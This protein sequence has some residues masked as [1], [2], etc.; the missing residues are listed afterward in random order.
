MKLKLTESKLKQIIAES[1]NE[2]LNE[3]SSDYVYN[4]ARR[5]HNFD[6]D[7]SQ[8]F[9]DYATERLHSELG[10]KPKGIIEASNLF[11]QYRN[12]HGDTIMIKPDGTIYYKER[13]ITRNGD[14]TSWPRRGDSTLQVSDEQ[15]ANF[16]AKWCAKYIGNKFSN[17]SNPKFWSTTDPIWPDE[18]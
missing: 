7:R 1:I 13:Q 2:V 8:K 9:H 16:L 15:T 10:G 18:E 6:P 5:T 14:F 11:I 12:I 17:T 3:I 4:V